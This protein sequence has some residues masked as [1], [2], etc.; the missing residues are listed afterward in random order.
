[1]EKFRHEIFA[2]PAIEGAA[3]F[4]KANQRLPGSVYLNI[5]TIFGSLPTR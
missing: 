1:L 2:A 5:D 4:L 3:F